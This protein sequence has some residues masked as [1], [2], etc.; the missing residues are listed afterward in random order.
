MD[1]PYELS[2]SNLLAIIDTQSG[3]A[4]Q[5]FELS[6]PVEFIE[7]ELGV[8]YLR[9]KGTEFLLWDINTYDYAGRSETAKL[10]LDDNLFLTISLE[11]E[12]Y[13]TVVGNPTTC[14]IGK[15]YSGPSENPIVS[16]FDQ[17]NGRLVYY[18]FEQDEI[19]FWDILNCKLINTIKLADIASQ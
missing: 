8:I 19:L 12:S 4:I 10:K 2:A 3:N 13:I 7:D 6:E 9:D 11:D 17:A 1:N 16:Q 18:D 14:K 5:Q 15:L